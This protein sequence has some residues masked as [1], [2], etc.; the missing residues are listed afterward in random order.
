VCN[1]FLQPFR[2]KTYDASWEWY[3]AKTSFLGVGLFYKDIGTYIQSLRT[4]VPYNQTGLP[5]S[6]LPPNF[7]GEEV[8]AVTTPVNTSGGPLKGYEINYQQALTMLPS[9]AKNLGVILNYTYVN[10]KINYLISPNA[11]TTITDDLLNLS[12]KSWNATIY[13][14]DGRLNARVAWAYRE[15][16]LTRVPGQNNNDVEGKNSS[17]NVDASLS[18]KINNNVQLIFEGVNLTNEKNDQFISRAR[19][20]SVVYSV[21]GREYMLGVRVAFP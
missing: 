10:S 2:A 16:F 20:S 1:P 9:Y 4:N 13:Y 18:Y 6:L 11:S 15:T 19:N 7:T 14:D 3:F 8:F 17:L 12:P 5:I 21:T